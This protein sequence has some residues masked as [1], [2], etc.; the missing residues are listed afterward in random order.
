MNRS[1]ETQGAIEVVYIASH[2][3]SG[4]TLLSLLLST[5]SKIVSI[6]ELTGFPLTDEGKLCSCG[7]RSDRCPFWRRIT[8]LLRRESK[9]ELQTLQT[10]FDGP[11][12][13][14]AI[15]GRLA[16]DALPPA[17]ADALRS[18]LSTH[19]PSLDRHIKRIRRSNVAVVRAALEVSGKRV[20]LDASK[21]AR[22]LRYLM[23]TPPFS[24]RAIHLVRDPRGVA[25]SVLR[26]AVGR[27]RARSATLA[28]IGWWWGERK[29]RRYSSMMPAGAC[30]TVVY[31]QLCAEPERTLERIGLFMG[32]DPSSFEPR[33]S[34]SDQH[35]LF[36]NAM[37][38][39]RQMTILRDDRWRTELTTAQQLRI[40]TIAGRTYRRYL[41]EP[42]ARSDA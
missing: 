14:T 36:G 38:S 21:Q 25:A 41:E 24:M 15:I 8:V 22:R 23:E 33:A 11:H 31:E 30:M 39:D 32:L 42:A 19:S 13:K 27:G 12:E 17:R 9:L 10:R 20:F 7:S 34:S 40:A 18:R 4:S 2:Y 29:I 35:V 37:R 3:F 1:A 28:A 6:G 26:R 5:H 16:M